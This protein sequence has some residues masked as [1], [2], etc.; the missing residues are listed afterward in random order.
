MGGLGKHFAHA[1]VQCT[2]CMTPFV[3][4][5]PGRNTRKSIVLQLGSFHHH[6]PTE[7]CWQNSVRQTPPRAR[8]NQP[9]G[10]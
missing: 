2:M 8:P 5:R 3:L 4:K 6:P 10:Y 7:V 1:A 9:A